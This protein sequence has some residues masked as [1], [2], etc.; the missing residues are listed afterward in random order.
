MTVP[1]NERGDRQR[2]NARACPY[3]TRRREQPAGQRAE[4][5]RVIRDD[6]N[7]RRSRTIKEGAGQRGKPV[8]EFDHPLH[9]EPAA[10]IEQFAHSGW[11]WME[12]MIKLSDWFAA[13]PGA[14]FYVPAPAW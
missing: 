4:Q 8:A 13:L 14:F 2:A 11:F 12:A 6:A 3:S 1:V 9:P 5:Q 7:P 10:V